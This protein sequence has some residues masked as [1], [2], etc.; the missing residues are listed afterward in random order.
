MIKH[1]VMFYFT[2]RVNDENREEVTALISDSV[3]R[4]ASADIKGLIRMEPVRNM[5]EG[6]PDIGLYCE[7]ESP[8]DLNAY[9]THPEHERHKALA[10]DYCRD[11][12][13]IDWE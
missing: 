5:A 4:M 13:V 10:K 11:R 3:R 6:M 2:D 12:I 1:I 8:D 9:Q 7:F